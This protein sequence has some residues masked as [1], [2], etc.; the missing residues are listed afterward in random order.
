MEMKQKVVNTLRK[1]ALDQIARA[2]SGHSG[3]ALGAAPL[4]LA[5]YSNAKVE[6]SDPSWFNRDRVVISAGHE[7]G[8]AHV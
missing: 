3:V 4:M 7:I 6:P 2:K 5:I 1:L 8:R